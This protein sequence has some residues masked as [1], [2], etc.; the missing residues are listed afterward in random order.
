[1]QLLFTRTQTKGK[2]ARVAFQLK[3]QLILDSEEQK[4]MERYRLDEA[5]LIAVLEPEL[6][7]RAQYIGVAVACMIGVLL[8][9]AQLAP[10]I[11]LGISGVAGYGAYYWYK[12]QYR[13]TVYVRDL[14]FG[15]HFTC[16]SVV[17]LARKEAWL[18]TA[19]SF[20]RQV[21]ESSKHW[22]EQEQ[23]MIDPL[24]PEEA[25]RVIIQGL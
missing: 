25:R 8:A 10:P 15:R 12:H 22:H 3:G 20:L 14:M 13:E 5:L 11:L 1:M 9:G 16:Q 19:V 2:L 24:P 17:E 23:Q 7:K 21:M 4:L 18:S 6:I